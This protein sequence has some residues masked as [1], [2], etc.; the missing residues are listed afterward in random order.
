MLLS[1]QY[2]PPYSACTC[3]FV[4]GAAL[5][6]ADAV[7][8]IHRFHLSPF[9]RSS[10]T[11]SKAKSKSK[12][13]AEEARQFLDDLDNLDA[14][15]AAPSASTGNAPAPN[16]ASNPSDAGDV[17]KFIDEITQ[18]S[19]EPTAPLER[20]SSRASLATPQGTMRRATERVRVGSPAPSSSAGSAKAEA[21]PA[22]AAPA[23]SSTPSASSQAESLEPSK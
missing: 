19:A 1:S 14:A 12:S 7:T 8:R 23:R 3:L 11:M 20:P 13:K 16:A 18:K 9:P 15:G 21:S 5:A 22:A 6:V 4:S 10:P 2:P 17:L